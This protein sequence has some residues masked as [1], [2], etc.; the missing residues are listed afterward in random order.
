[1]AGKYDT[2]EGRWAGVGPYYAMF[3][4]SFADDVVSQYSN[5]GDTVFDPFAG[6]ATSIYSA[7][8]LGR[9]GIGIEINPVGWVYGKAKLQPA[10]MLDVLATIKRISKN[11]AYYSNEA[12]DLPL[13]FKKCFTKKVRKFLLAARR[14]LNWKRSV[15]DWTAMA[16]LLVYLHGKSDASFSNQMRQTKSMSPPYAISWW[17]RH[18]SKPPDIDPLDFMKNRIEWRYA[19]GQPQRFKSKILLG[20]CIS[21]LPKLR[22]DIDNSSHNKVNLLFTSPPYCGITDYHYDQWLRLWLLGYSSTATKSLGR[23]RGKFTSQQQYRILLEKTFM[24]A[25]KILDKNAV[26]YVRTDNRDFT[27][28]TTQDVLKRT[29]P[30]K[31]YN[32]ISQPFIR[33]TQTHLFGDKRP[34]LGEIDIILTPE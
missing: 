26:V 17:D 10:S 33:P 23:H 11:S 31:Q 30:D 1:M 24:G 29:F 8:M 7:A 28:T 22:K 6:R 18:N 16:L 4:K 34:Q 27:L 20:D 25:S 32:V 2:P 5:I 3:P 14:E 12:D 9:K 19:K 21:L 15:S 13:F